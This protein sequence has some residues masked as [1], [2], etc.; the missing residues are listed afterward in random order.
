MRKATTTTQKKAV[1]PVSK[2]GT[3]AKKTKKAQE[4]EIKKLTL[5]ERAAEIK[6]LAE[7]S[8]LADDFY[9]LTTFDR[10]ETQIKILT[11]LKKTIEAE[12]TLIE[13]EYVKGRK[14]LYT[15]P[16]ISE[17]NRTTDS[18]NKTVTCLLKIL[19]ARNQGEKEEED[20][21]LK[22]MGEV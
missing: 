13:K 10:Y 11:E 4:E 16:A 6:R 14:N 5:E 19:E 8:G 3:R 15:H 22:I 2:P 21:L 1:R 9:F 17:Y 7:E 12:D 18:A 20:P